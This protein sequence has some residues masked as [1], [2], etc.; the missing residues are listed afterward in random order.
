M[1]IVHSS[2]YFSWKYQWQLL[3]S[4]LTFDVLQYVA[5]VQDHKKFIGWRA[6]IHHF[7]LKDEYLYFLEWTDDYGDA[8]T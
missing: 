1:K 2:L 6:I 4:F 5:W 7:V 3:F 8:Q